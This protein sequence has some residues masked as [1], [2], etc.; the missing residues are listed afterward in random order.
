MNNEYEIAYLKAA[1]EL[2][3]LLKRQEE[4]EGR[5]LALRKTM[6]AL[7]SLIQQGGELVN[8]ERFAKA[9]RLVQSSFTT[10]TEDVFKIVSHSIEPL[11]TT[12]V[13]DEVL[14]LGGSFTE[15]KNQLATVNAVLGRLTEQDKIKEVMKESR[16]AWKRV[17]PS[18]TAEE[19][20]TFR[21]KQK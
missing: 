15:H 20:Q 21:K 2:E 7:S 19:L 13:R 16:R 5:I 12:D 6:T 1:D 11:T 17:P 10:L 4:T 9:E 14:K 8:A 3:A 18:M